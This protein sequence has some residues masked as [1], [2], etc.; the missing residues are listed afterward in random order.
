MDCGTLGLP[1]PHHLPEFAQ[2]HVHWIGDTIQPSHPLSPSSLF[3]FN[4]SQHQGLLWWVS[5][6]H[7]VAK[8]LEFQLQPWAFFGSN[9]AKGETPVLWPPHG[10]SWFIEKDSVAGR[11]WGQEEKGTTEDEMAG[12]HHQLDGHEFEQAPGIGDGQR[13]LACC[14]PWGHKMTHN[15]V[16]E[17]NYY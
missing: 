9:D 6:S 12:W 4:L 14:S 16:T 7:Q 3:A 15:W 2:V 11:D 17:L 8:E 10:K 13:S 1:V 5:S